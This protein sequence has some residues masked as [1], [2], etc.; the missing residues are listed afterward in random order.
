MT[1]TFRNK[2]VID[3]IKFKIFFLNRY[4]LLPNVYKPNRDFKFE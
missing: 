4:I 3:Q 1:H 2:K